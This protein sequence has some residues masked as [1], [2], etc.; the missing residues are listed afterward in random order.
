MLSTYRGWIILTILVGSV[1]F[2]GYYKRQGNSNPGN[3][4]FKDAIN[5]AI[6][7]ERDRAKEE[8]DQLQS[9]IIQSAELKAKI[10]E[11]IKEFVDK[12][13]DS[14][15]SSIE[16]NERN[17]H[18][19]MKKQ[20]EDQ[21]AAKKSQLESANDPFIGS[22]DAKS[23]VVIFYDYQCGYCRESFKSI[24]SIADS[25]PNVKFILKVYPVL[26]RDSEYLA[27][28]ATAVFVSNPEKFDLINK[29]FLSEKAYTKED[30]KDLF[31]ENGM[32]FNA[33]EEMSN[34]K[35]VADIVNAN[36]NLAKDLKLSGVPVFVINGNFYPGFLSEDFLT[37]FINETAPA[38]SSPVSITSEVT[39]TP[40]AQ[41]SQPEVKSET[42]DEP[43][44][45][46]SPS[47]EAKADNNNESGAK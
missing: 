4:D 41:S 3:A 24:Y 17:K 34:S 44:N 30:V 22:V 40:P 42:K 29:E 8:N 15:I 7:E 28:L 10:Q 31:A 27:K 6:K 16:Q 32:D 13:P 11:V 21:L 25:N 26:G 38:E 20:I 5:A 36:V 33:I 18:M 37:K 35:K 9:K 19:A 47:T 46:L 12:N 45:S 43:K 14:I 1:A 23:V 39:A 2:L